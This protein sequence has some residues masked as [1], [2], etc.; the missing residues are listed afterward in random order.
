M[1]LA[2]VWLGFMQ[3]TQRR[4]TR[5]CQ[6]QSTPH[7]VDGGEATEVKPFGMLETLQLLFESSASVACCNSLGKT[8]QQLV[9]PQGTL[10]FGGFKREPKGKPLRRFGDRG[11]PDPLRFRLSDFRGAGPLGR[12]SVAKGTHLRRQPSPQGTPPPLCAWLY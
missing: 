1:R 10:C 11:P 2:S 12:R 6:A 3:M 5:R 4:L 9:S 7:K 8:T